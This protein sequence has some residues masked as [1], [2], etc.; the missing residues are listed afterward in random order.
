MAPTATFSTAHGRFCE[1]VSYRC[2]ET[3]AGVLPAALGARERRAITVC[4]HELL[5]A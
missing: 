5:P 4:R 3:S 2:G 1:V